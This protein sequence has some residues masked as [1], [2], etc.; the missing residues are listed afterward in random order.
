MKATQ[1]L[2]LWSNEYDEHE[3]R[4]RCKQPTVL[5][6]LLSAVCNCSTL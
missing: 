3:L 4:L 1:E 5:H 2:R 6:V